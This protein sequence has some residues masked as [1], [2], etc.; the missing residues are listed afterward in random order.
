MVARPEA[1]IRVHV[2][3]LCWNERRMLPYFL[4]HYRSIAERFVV[5]DDGSDDGSVE[6]LL[7]FDDVEVRP[8][9]NDGDSFVEAERE[10]YEHCWKECRGHAD[11]VITPNVDEHLY[12]ADFSGLLKKYRTKGITAVPALGYQMVSDSF[13][14]TSGR[15]CD[16]VRRGMPW[17]MMNKLLVFDPN[18][19]ESIGFGLGIHDASPVG[20]VAYPGRDELRLLHFKYLGLPYLIARRAELGSR[21]KSAD[22]ERG[23]GIKYLR[24]ESKTRA[25]FEEV[26]RNAVTAVGPGSAPLEEHGTERWWR[27]SPGAERVRD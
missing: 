4:S 26:T 16:V 18:A 13:P 1:S 22:V 5:F 10:L 12:H 3:A 11:W 23:L 6:Y 25:A 24:S 8:F 7:G 14:D 27:V 19:I 2:Y 15:L 20:R 21:L 9:A 17:N